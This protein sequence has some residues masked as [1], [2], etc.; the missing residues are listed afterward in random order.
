MR[1]VE[2]Y[3]W[4]HR[5]RSREYKRMLLDFT[6]AQ[7]AYEESYLNM[8]SSCNFDTVRER[9]RK[10]AKPVEIKAMIVI[11]RHRAQVES[12]ERR[13][14]EAKAIIDAIEDTISRAGLNSREREYVR[15]RYFCDLTAQAVALRMFVSDATSGRIRVA[16]LVKIRKVMKQTP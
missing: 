10:I 16:A 14:K 1:E 3:L 13:M 6:L 9:N 2:K 8:P 7:H 12:I 15:M 11:D 5:A 4:E